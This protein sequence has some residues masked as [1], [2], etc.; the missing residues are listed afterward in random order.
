MTKLIQTISAVA[1]VV[2]LAGCGG[3]D[4][5]GGTCPAFTPCGGSP[6]GTW[7]IKDYCVKNVPNPLGNQCMGATVSAD[8]LSASGTVTY[9]A[10]MTTSSNVTLK[11]SIKMSVPKSCLP[12]GATC[13]L[14]NASL[15][16]EIRDP[17]SDIMSG[18]CSGGDTCNCTLTMKPSAEM[19]TGTWRMMGNLLIEDGDDGLEYCVKGNELLIREPMSMGGMMGGMMEVSVSARLTKK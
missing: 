11:G 15:Q 1:L 8:G 9:N 4:S 13:E 18:S 2:G 7:E 19:S 16:E 5:G 3:G 17:T 12:F 6:V 10:D 14:L